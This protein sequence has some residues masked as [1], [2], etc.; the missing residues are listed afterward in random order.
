[1]LLLPR[2]SKRFPPM[3]VVPSGGVCRWCCAVLVFSSGHKL[4]GQVN[5]RRRWCSEHETNCV[6][7]YLI[8]HRQGHLRKALWKRD[9]GICCECDRRCSKADWQADHRIPLW[10]LPETVELHE[11][12]KYWGLANGQT[13]CSECHGKKTKEEAGLRAAI[14]RRATKEL[15]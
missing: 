1:M 12:S 9:R 5:P 10:S 4:A 3:P 15:L 13:L 2:K 8:S 11:R 7:N 14:R 6:L